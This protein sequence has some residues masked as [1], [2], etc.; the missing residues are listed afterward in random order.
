MRRFGGVSCALAM[1]FGGGPALA[2][3]PAIP[4]AAHAAFRVYGA[5]LEGFDYPFPVRMF[6]TTA[7]GRPIEM[8]YMELAPARPNGRTVVLLHGKNFCAATWGDTARVL[9]AAGYRVIAPDQIGFCK[10]SKPDGF[11]YSLPQL[12]ALTAELLRSRGVT[13]ATIVGHSFGG[14]L[15]MRMAIAMPGLVDQLVLVNPL[16][17]TD[18][19]AQGVPYADIGQFAAQEDK[20][21]AASIR[22]YEQSVYYHGTWRRSYDRWVEMLAGL[23]AGSGHAAV[24]QAQARL[25]EMIESQPVAYELHRIQAPT[26]LMIGMLDT[27]ALGRDRAP[28]ELRGGVP[29]IPASAAKAAAKMPHGRLVP[30]PGLGHAP[31]VEDPGRF[32]VAL[33]QALGGALD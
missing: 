24:A 21:D 28:P 1:L 4:P 15:A 13:Q 6:R 22:A 12:A 23:Y 7:Q 18:Q 11:Q 9:A 20:R 25:S 32:Q 5:Q 3:T 2:Q 30:L 17:L 8:A 19:L 16:G 29:T 31:Q 10:S 14:M 33:L 26:V 27:T